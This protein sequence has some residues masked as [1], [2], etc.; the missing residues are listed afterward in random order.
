MDYCL[1]CSNTGRY[2]QAKDNEKFEKEFDRLDDMGCF[3]HAHCYKEAM[4]YAGYNILT[5]CPHC[6]KSPEDYSK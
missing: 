4:D 1:Q 2:K 3:D 5:P 6:G